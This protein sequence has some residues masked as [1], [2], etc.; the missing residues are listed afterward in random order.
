VETRRRAGATT[1]S[2]IVAVRRNRY[3]RVNRRHPWKVRYRY[4]VEG[5]FF[6]KSEELWDLPAGYAGGP[7]VAAED[8]ARD[9]GRSTPKCP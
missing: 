8:D 5:E 7:A 1:S 3:V 6:D 9:P 2:T 4:E